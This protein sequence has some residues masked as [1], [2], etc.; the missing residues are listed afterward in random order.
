MAQFAVS[1]K[2]KLPLL[3]DQVSRIRERVERSYDGIGALLN[4]LGGVTTAFHRAVRQDACAGNELS[5]RVAKCSERRKHEGATI[6]EDQTLCADNFGGPLKLSREPHSRNGASGSKSAL[7][8]E[9]AEDVNHMIANVMGTLQ[10]GDI[11]CQ[12][13][14]NI[15]RSLLAVQDAELSFEERAAFMSM[16]TD[17]I[18][19]TLTELI[20]NC[21]AFA[22]NIALIAGKVEKVLS[23]ASQQ[24]V[25][26]ADGNRNLQERPLPQ[27][28]EPLPQQSL[29]PS[30]LEE[31][32]N[33]LRAEIPRLHEIAEGADTTK[34]HFA[35][36]RRE[37]RDPRE[38]SRPVES[39]SL[40][41]FALYTMNTEREIHK[42]HFW[43]DIDTT[44]GDAI[45]PFATPEATE[46]I[47]LGSVLF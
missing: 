44:D 32:V 6:E 47:D 43:V 37:T 4:Q 25:R 16:I 39:L 46:G 14:D 19:S 27:L 40:Q 15:G 38:Q 17:Q 28:S 5:E 34:I 10:F 2:D 1:D 18:C 22:E 13:L 31:L 20:S 41:I 8:R 9:V 26:L 23:N 24:R 33:S 11:T 7:L 35:D 36:F 12:R 42:R 29:W 3:I 21:S 30:E 45:N